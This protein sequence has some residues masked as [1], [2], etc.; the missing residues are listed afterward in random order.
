MTQEEFYLGA[1]GK[2]ADMAKMAAET[3]DVMAF[4]GYANQYKAHPI[5]VRRGEQIRMYVLDAGPSKW[6]AFHVIGTVFDRTVV[7]GVVGHDSQTVSLGAEPG[8]LGRVHARPGGQL[9]VRHPLLR[10]H[11]QG[12]RGHPAHDRR[13]EGRRPRAPAPAATPGT[14]WRATKADVN[15]TL[16]DMWVK[17]DTTTV[18]AGKVTFAVKNTGATMHG[19]AI[20]AAPAKVGGGMLDESTLRRQGQEPRG[21]RARHASRP[22]SSPAGTSSCASCPATTWP[23]RSW[24]SRSSSARPRRPQRSRRSCWG[25]SAIAQ[26]AHAAS[27]RRDGRVGAVQPAC[28]VEEVLRLGAAHRGQ[29]P[30]DRDPALGAALGGREGRRRARS[31]SGGRYSPATLPCGHHSGAPSASP[32]PRRRRLRCP[33]SSR[34][35]TTG[36][37]GSATSSA[38]ASRAM[39]AAARRAWCVA[40]PP[41]FSGETTPS[42][43][44]QVRRHPST[45]P[46]SSARMKPSSSQG[47]PLSPGPRGV[48]RRRR[49]GRRASRRPARAAGRRGRRAT[50]PVLSSTRPSAAP[51]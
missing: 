1:P 46:S 11:G 12:R 33:T 38:P 47:T 27:E 23:A 16:G 28:E 24:P 4:N 20:V 7:E 15:A 13:A 9:P 44:A 43:A 8:R 48:A 50:T 37:P 2:P 35:C 34:P 39:A 18:K 40:R 36:S 25:G 19:L 32:R 42:P 14:T 51:R 29:R 3:P 22:T 17:A 41:N 5:T 49:A 30:V 21:R 26:L 31:A 6:S 45:S 10:R